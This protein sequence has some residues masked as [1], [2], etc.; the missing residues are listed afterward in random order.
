MFIKLKIIFKNKVKKKRKYKDSVAVLD[1]KAN[2]KGKQ[3]HEIK[4]PVEVIVIGI[5][6]ESQS[7]WEGYLN[8][9]I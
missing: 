4:T 1:G 6:I 9:W 8:H 3:S 5:Y 2:P 7:F